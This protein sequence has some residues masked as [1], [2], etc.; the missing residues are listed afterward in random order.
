MLDPYLILIIDLIYHNYDC[1]GHIHACQV[2]YTSSDCNCF[3]GDF[4]KL[5]N[6]LKRTEGSGITGAFIT[7]ILFFCSTVLGAFILYEYLVYIHRDG[8]ILDLWRRITSP[9]STFFVPDDLEVSRDE[10]MHALQKAR[11]W[12]GPAGARRKVV[13]QEGVEKDPEHKN[14]LAR[15]TRYIVN[16]VEKDG[17][18]AVHRQF[19]LDH[20]GKIV[21][22]FEDHKV[23][24]QRQNV[25]AVFHKNEGGANPEGTVAA[26]GSDHRDDAADI[27]SRG[28][29]HQDDS[30]SDEDDGNH[31]PKGTN[32][33]QGS[34]NP[35]LSGGN[36][37]DN[38]S[39]RGSHSSSES[40]AHSH[41]SSSA[42]D[43]VPPASSTSQRG[44]GDVLFEQQSSVRTYLH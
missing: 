9:P 20:E 16:E 39:R 6:R 3:N 14:Y 27:Q 5:A 29:R 36:Q 18:T 12:I 21:E 17:T 44:A 25:F 22:V 31:R 2:S 19:V 8:R 13:I 38:H 34:H 28:S 41:R 37:G 30:H 11:R 24:M 7:I 40:K 42:T 1:G 26:T 15:F 35:M 4:I 43:F 32:S 33:R 10:L 23:K